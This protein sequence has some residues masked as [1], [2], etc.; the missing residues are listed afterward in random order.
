[1]T[2]AGAALV[3]AGMVA[4]I[5]GIVKPDSAQAGGITALVAGVL[6]VALPLLAAPL[7]RRAEQAVSDGS[8]ARP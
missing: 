7:R 3:A 5:V 4:L 8:G 1:T 6:L 2:W